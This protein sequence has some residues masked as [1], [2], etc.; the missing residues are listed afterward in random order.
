MSDKKEAWQV[1]TSQQ[2]MCYMESEISDTVQA[3]L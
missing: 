2:E 1:R 3:W